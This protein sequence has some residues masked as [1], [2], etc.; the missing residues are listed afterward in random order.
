MRCQNSV[1]VRVSPKSDLESTAAS[2]HE[3][4]VDGK[5]ISSSERTLL[6]VVTAFWTF[7]VTRKTFVL[8]LIRAFWV[9][10]LD[11]SCRFICMSTVHACC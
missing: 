5:H 6:V 11:I 1:V 2:I 9:E 7:D 3:H 4:W 10:C 8:A